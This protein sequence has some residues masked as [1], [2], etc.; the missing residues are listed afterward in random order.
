MKKRILAVG[1]ILCLLL[2]LFMI[3]QHFDLTGRWRESRVA[4]MPVEVTAE[5]QERPFARDILQWQSQNDEVK[6]WLHVPDSNISEPLVQAADNDFYLTRDATKANNR[7]GAAFL[8]YEIGAIES[9]DHVI[10][11]GHNNEN[12]RAFS[13]LSRYLDRT[14]ADAHPQ[15]QVA[16]L[17]G[18]TLYE[19]VLVVDMDVNN[20][21]SFFGFNTWLDWDAS[22]HA[23]SYIAEMSKRAV[24]DSGRSVTEKDRLLTLSTCDNSRSNARYIIVARAVSS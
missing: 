21:Q 18:S 15:F 14:Y 17:A 22:N 4:R 1:S 20:P 7:N 13:D 23:G 5:E 12:G 11:Y 6:G 10:V 16:T 2:S 8:D 24:Y 19:L 3:D 9:A